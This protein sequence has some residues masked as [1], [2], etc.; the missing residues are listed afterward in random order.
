VAC[1]TN[2]NWISRA[3]LKVNGKPI[4][5]NNF[6]ENFISQAVIGMVQSLRGV[7]DVDTISLKISKETK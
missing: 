6:V 2:Q 5:L 1:K 7:G 4:E 3:E